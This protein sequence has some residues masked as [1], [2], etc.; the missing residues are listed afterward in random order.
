MKKLMQTCVLWCVFTEQLFV[1][2]TYLWH[3]VTYEAIDGVVHVLKHMPNDKTPECDVARMQAM[4]SQMHAEG[5][6]MRLLGHFR[7]VYVY[8]HMLVYA[9]EKTCLI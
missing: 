7:Y 9:V 8:E 5:L 1:F 4:L 6:N 3:Q 2:L